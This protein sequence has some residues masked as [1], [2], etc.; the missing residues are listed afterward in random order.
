MYWRQVLRSNDSLQL[1]VSSDPEQGNIIAT[2]LLLLDLGHVLSD[3]ILQCA[4]CK[5]MPFHS[6]FLRPRSFHSSAPNILRLFGKFHQRKIAIAL[7]V[8]SSLPQSFASTSPLM[9]FSLSDIFGKIAGAAAMA[10]WSWIGLLSV[11]PL[12]RS[13]FNFSINKIRFRYNNRPL[14]TQPLT[15]SLAHFTSFSVLGLVWF[16]KILCIHI[17]KLF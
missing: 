10:T 13:S 3:P 12:F 14:S 5:S 17:S 15:R 1:T 6:D 2:Q 9:H 11:S 16:G 4:T 8:Q 7:F